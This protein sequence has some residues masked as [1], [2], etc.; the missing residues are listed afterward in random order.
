[1]PRPA[2]GPVIE[3]KTKR[4]TSFAIRFGAPGLRAPVYHSRQHR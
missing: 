3:R 4:G 2:R 1:M